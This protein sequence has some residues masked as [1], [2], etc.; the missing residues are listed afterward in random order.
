M[1]NRLS[2]ENLETSSYASGPTWGP[3]KQ[4]LRKNLGDPQYCPD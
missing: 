2:G 3:T 4:K 1:I